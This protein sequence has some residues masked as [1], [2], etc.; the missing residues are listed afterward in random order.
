M[1]EKMMSQNKLSELKLVPYIKP[2]KGKSF[3]V[4]Q[5]GVAKSGLQKEKNP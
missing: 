1:S 3:S 4:H 2:Q 5:S